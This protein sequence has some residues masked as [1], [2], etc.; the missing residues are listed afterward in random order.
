MMD[1][2]AA[3]RAAVAA[4]PALAKSLQKDRT[5]LANLKLLAQ[6]PPRPFAAPSSSVADYLGTEHVTA[7]WLSCALGQPPSTGQ[8]RGAAGT[9]A[10]LANMLAARVGR[11]RRPEDGVRILSLDGGGTRALVTIEMLKE[12]ERQ[13][14]Q[15]IH[16]LFDVIAGT[17]TVRASCLIFF[18]ARRRARDVCV[19]GCAVRAR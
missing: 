14:G 19:C 16:D 18:F 12:L 11:G 9:R 17:S 2:L 10:S 3:L 6:P 5:L 1:D 7:T 8:P 4:D 13:T 15:R